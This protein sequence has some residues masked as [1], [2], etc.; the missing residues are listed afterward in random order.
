MV[1]GGTGSP[2]TRGSGYVQAIV[3]SL[4]NLE[5]RRTLNY[6]C[7]LL[8]ISRASLYFLKFFFL[9]LF[10]EYK[11]WEKFLREYYGQKDLVN[12]PY[13][14]L[15]LEKHSAHNQIN[16]SEDFCRKKNPCNLNISQFLGLWNPS[17]S[18]TY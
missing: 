2:S 18:S 1:L 3:S 12:P 5:I 17:F 15:S 13:H 8:S 16:A 14:L 10:P 7:P 6:K 4:Q 9:F 11:S